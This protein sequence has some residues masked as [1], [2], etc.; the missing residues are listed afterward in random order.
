V[1]EASPSPP[2]QSGTP[3]TGNGSLSSFEQRSADVFGSLTND[4]PVASDPAAEGVSSSTAPASPSTAGSDD[5][6]RA[7]ERAERRQRYNQLMAEERARVDAQARHRQSAEALR[8]AERIE[9]ENEELRRQTASRIDPSK[10]DEQGFF[11]LAEQLNVAPQKLGQWLQQRAMNPELIAAQAAAKQ[12]DPKLQTLERQNQE[13]R[14]RLDRFEAQQRETHERAEAHEKA[15]GLLT[16][17]ENAA[18]QAPYTAA[19]LRNYGPEEFITLANSAYARVPKVPGWEQAVVDEIED[20]LS[21]LAKIYSPAS[22]NPQQRQA[23]P[24]I[25]HAAAKAPTTVSNTLAQG[26]ASVVD[27]AQDWASLSF[28]E[29][30]RRAFG[31]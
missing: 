4:A 29:R 10:L 14:E 13:L 9:R 23:P 31:L 25:N 15:V 16:F 12:V 19:F 27:E 18:A 24:S 5:E 30:S 20:H 3:D 26:R 2:Q 28:E 8:R 17:T 22:G 11:D 6:K 1:N 21:S 7:A